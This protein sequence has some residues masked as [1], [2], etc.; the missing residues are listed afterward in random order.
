VEDLTSIAIIEA[1][2]TGVSKWPSSITIT[3]S[4]APIPSGINDTVPDNP[5]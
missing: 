4:V 2:A 3:A 1:M 5:F